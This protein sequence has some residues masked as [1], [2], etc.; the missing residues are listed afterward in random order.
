MNDFLHDI[1]QDIQSKMSKDFD[2]NFRQRLIESGVDPDNLELLKHRITRVYIEGDEF[3][4]FY[5][6]YGKST[7]RR[8]L[9]FQRIPTITMVE[10]GNNYKF[11]AEQK[12]Y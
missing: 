6:D 4:H 7:E 3:E 1:I 2:G 5:L 11:T 8:I 9:S 12:Y 10:E